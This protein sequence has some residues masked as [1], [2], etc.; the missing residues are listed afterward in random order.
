MESKNIDQATDG[1]LL[2]DIRKII[3]DAR[4]SVAATVNA[5]LT[6]L[7]WRVGQRIKE[8]VLSRKRADYGKEIVVTLS[9]QLVD[10]YGNGFT[11]K[12][13]LIF[14]SAALGALASCRPRPAGSDLVPTVSVGMQSP[15]LQ[16]RVSV[17]QRGA[18]ATSWPNR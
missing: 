6:L 7:Y 13:A 1:A 15:P 16:R 5:Q 11:E 3:T 14:V 17:S 2:T 10:E 9:R 18:W 4:A 8:D 12:K